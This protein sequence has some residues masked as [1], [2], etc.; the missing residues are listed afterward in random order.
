MSLR[1]PEHYNIQETFKTYKYLKE[2][3]EKLDKI[4]LP[5]SISFNEFCKMNYERRFDKISELKGVKDL[6]QRYKRHRLNHVE[7]RHLFS[8]INRV[9]KENN[10]LTAL[11]EI[12]RLSFNS[13]LYSIENISNALKGFPNYLLVAIYYKKYKEKLKSVISEN[14]E[15]YDLEIRIEEKELILFKNMITEQINSLEVVKQFNRNDLERLEMARKRNT[16]LFKECS[17]IL[18]V[19][20]D[21][22]NTF[23][24]KYVDREEVDLLLQYSRNKQIHTLEPQTHKKAS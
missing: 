19:I 16:V 13:R 3:L 5:A 20:S 2:R 17:I 14:E 1:I 10:L 4:L 15:L 7:N 22:V 18:D 6:Y 23:S 9:F 21:K 11:F 12:K 8:S 24:P